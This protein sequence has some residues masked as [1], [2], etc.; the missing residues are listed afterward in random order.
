MPAVEPASTLSERAS[1]GMISRTQRSP[2][3]C[4]TY[5]AT[6]WLAPLAERSTPPLPA[7]KTLLLGFFVEPLVEAINL[8]FEV[9]LVLVAIV[10][11]KRALDF[12]KVKEHLENA[13]DALQDQYDDAM[14]RLNLSRRSSD[15][16]RVSGWESRLGTPRSLASS[17]GSRTSARAGLCTS[18]VS[19]RASARAEVSARAEPQRA[20]K[21]R[22]AQSPQRVARAKVPAR[23]EAR[24][25]GCLA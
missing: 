14:G 17:S 20:L 6:P 4:E 8:V 19:A 5:P 9:S 10:F 2:A 3:T 23:A 21:P 1:S 7:G 18:R 15:G 24:A 16:S 11:A 12:F 22:D 13:I 25:F